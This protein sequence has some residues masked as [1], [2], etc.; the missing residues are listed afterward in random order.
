[1]KE[2]LAVLMILALSACGKTPPTFY[3]S[4]KGNVTSNKDGTVIT[5][6]SHSVYLIKEASNSVL[7]RNGAG[8]FINVCSEKCRKSTVSPEI[9][10]YSISGEQQSGYQSYTEVSIQQSNGAMSIR[11]RSIQDTP[12]GARVVASLDGRLT[13]ERSEHEPKDE[14]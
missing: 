5:S 13:C 10:E 9:I 2:T 12:E 4:C 3:L 1:M 6:S 14:A 11:S 7:L 8:E